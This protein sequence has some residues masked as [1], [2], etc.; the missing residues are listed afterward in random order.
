MRIGLDKSWGEKYGVSPVIYIHKNSRIGDAV[1]SLGNS[2]DGYSS[3]MIKEGSDMNIFFMIS[4]SLNAVSHLS[5]YVKQYERTN[6]EHYI[7]ND[8]KYSFKK[9][10]F[11]DEREWRFVPPMTPESFWLINVDTMENQEELEKAH[12]NLIK[13][14][15]KFSLD[16]IRYIVCETKDEKEKLENAIALK[17]DTTKEQINS[18]IKFHLSS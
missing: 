13:H 3:S 16:D 5:Y 12:N 11:Y 18:K 6:D 15:L 4:N 7:I 9:G 1:S 17:F 14:S 2:F 10:R 8:K